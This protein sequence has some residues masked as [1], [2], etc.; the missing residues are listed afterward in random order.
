VVAKVE[1]LLSAAQ[2]EGAARGA[3]V[4]IGG[5]PTTAAVRDPVGADAWSLNPSRGVQLCGEFLAAR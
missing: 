4:I 3:V 2:Q 1:P 5:G